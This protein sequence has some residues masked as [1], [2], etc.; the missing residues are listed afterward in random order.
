M[1]LKLH[2]GLSKKIGL[3]DYG[4]LGASCSVEIELDHGLLENDLAGFHERVRKTFVACRQAVGDELARQQ[5]PPSEPVTDTN[6]HGKTNGTTRG[7]DR[8]RRATVAQVRALHAIT[9]RQGLELASLVL[10]RYG[11][12]P[13]GLSIIEASQLIDELKSPVN[14]TGG[15]R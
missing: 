5:T 3:P 11:V 4:S 6:G 12:E 7:R 15:Q 2:V 14:G 13:E 10:N 1:P 8:T 9:D